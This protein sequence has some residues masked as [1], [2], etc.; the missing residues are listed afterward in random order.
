MKQVQIHNKSARLK[1]ISCGGG[2]TVTVPPSETPITITLEN[3]DEVK[4]FHE[5]LKNPAVKRWLDAGEVVIG[6]GSGGGQS[7]NAPPASPPQSGSAQPP[8]PKPDPEPEH[9]PT[10]GRR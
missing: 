5:A 1:H 8:E 3:D 4:R 10:R 7:S 9:P 6:S 2:M